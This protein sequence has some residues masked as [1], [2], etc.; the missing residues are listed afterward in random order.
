MGGGGIRE[1]RVVA[2][3]DTVLDPLNRGCRGRGATPRPGQNWKTDD[4]KLAE[5]R[6]GLKNGNIIACR[7]K[8][9]SNEARVIHKS[10]GQEKKSQ[11]G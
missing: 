6:A 5:D 7:H 10:G 1:G 2:M 4:N 11:S 8:V 3:Q 9:F